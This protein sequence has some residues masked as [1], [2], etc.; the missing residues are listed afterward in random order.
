MS[1]LA[2][3][4]VWVGVGALS[5]PALVGL[6]RRRRALAV[7]PLALGLLSLLAA[8]EVVWPG[9]AA[10]TGYGATL[11]LGRPGLGLLVVAGVALAV[12]CG[13]APVVEGGEVTAACLVG[14]AAVV[15]LSATVPAVWA[16]ASAVA[17]AAVAVRWI[18]AAPGRS[19]L[20][21]GRV[22]G[23]GAAALLGAAIF[24]PATLGP[25]DA[26]T[27]VAGA[28]LA[29]GVGA[30]LALVP[31]GGWAAAAA[32]GVRGTDLAL[33]TLLLAPAV[34]LSAGAAL[35]A[36]PA[37]TRD[38]F[39]TDLLVLALLSGLYSG[40]QAVRA[41]PE[42]R[43][44]RLFIADLAL[45]AAGLASLHET[46]RLGGMLLVLTHLIVGPLLLHA[47]RPGLERQRRLA[48]FAL[49]GLP[50]A[51][52]FWG[53]LLVLQGLAETS[54]PVLVIGLVAFAAI[55]AAAVRALV[56]PDPPAPGRAT[57]GPVRLLA[58]AV[59]LAALVLGLAPAAIAERVFGVSFT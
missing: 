15:M 37:A 54:G 12:V 29:A 28:L 6:P 1:P 59:C 43:Y 19:T 50:G 20:A 53:R 27:R 47:P 24:L 45:A 26:R 42:A 4:L 2:L 21:M 14:A 22:A 57:G 3:A 46:G 40:V 49:A 31:L 11:V 5:A 34:L 25:E 9:P 18:A 32:S 33:W 35:P 8:S 30:L 55:T 51:A 13:L 39:A 36:L 52:A 10:S 23:L 16:G 58:W 17:V 56:A 41:Q 38:A 44:G 7:T 48:W